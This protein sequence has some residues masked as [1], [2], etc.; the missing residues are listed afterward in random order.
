MNFVLGIDIGGTNTVFGA[1]DRDGNILIEGEMSTT[2]AKEAPEFFRLLSLEI[3]KKLTERDLGDPIGIGVGAPNANYYTCNIEYP[4]NLSWKGITNI[5]DMLN[6]YF[7]VPIVSTND[8]NAAAL[9][10]MLYGNAKGMNNFMQVTI[11]TGLGGGLIVNGELVY[12]KDGFAGE[13]GHMRC[14]RMDRRCTCD[15]MGCLET[16][17]SARGIVKT[18]VEQHSEEEQKKL[19]IPN[20]SVKAIADMARNGNEYALKTF[21]ETA[22]VLGE[23]LA[24]VVNLH[25]PE[26]VILFGGIC[27]SA[28]L[29]L[30]PV[31]SYMEE[32][33]MKIFKDKVKVMSS[34]LLDLN[35]AVL[36]AA[37]L[38]W[39]ELFDLETISD[40]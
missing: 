29:F 14:I 23:H 26:A 7:N 9:G 20:L 15:R 27:R 21:D 5:Y 2:V 10:E 34:G 40:F 38:I 28:E 17:V 13:L 39:K 6:P 37:A 36:G 3:H 1:V 19:D 8:A 30:K 31:K 4:P 32:N 11:G 22:Y 25:S 16:Y 33:V 24:Q 35:A 12:G 18:F